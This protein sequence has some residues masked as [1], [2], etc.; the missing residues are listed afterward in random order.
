[1]A[2][3]AAGALVWVFD[4]DRGGDCISLFLSRNI[5]LRKVGRKKKYFG[6]AAVLDHPYAKYIRG[7]TVVPALKFGFNYKAVEAGNPPRKANEIFVR[8]TH[9]TLGNNLPFAASL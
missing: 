4:G 5:L 7:P 2:T 6:T 3:V 8:G 9:Q 1:M